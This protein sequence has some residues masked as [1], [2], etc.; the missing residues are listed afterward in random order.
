[1]IVISSNISLKFLSSKSGMLVSFSF[2]N[3]L[4]KYSLRVFAV[5]LSL[6]V[7]I[8]FGMRSVD[9]DFFV[10]EFLLT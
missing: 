2:V 1:M 8:P 9:T 10:F 5:S 7:G 4:E 3:T 6:D